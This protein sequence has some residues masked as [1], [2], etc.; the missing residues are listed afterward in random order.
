MGLEQLTDQMTGLQ[1]AN[2][3]KNNFE[4]VLDA[5]SAENKAENAGLSIKTDYD[6]TRYIDLQLADGT[7]V[8]MKMDVFCQAIAPVVAGL[9]GEANNYQRGLM[10]GMYTHV[11][12]VL[13]ANGSVN[14]GMFKGLIFWQ[15]LYS[16]SYWHLFFVDGKDSA[17]SL[18]NKSMGYGKLKT[19]GG[20][21]IYSTSAGTP[22]DF[23]YYILRMP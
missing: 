2:A 16:Y 5:E 15:D 1:M 6:A 11:K 18:S 21:V 4:K 12:T 10:P 8:K 13:P 9:I 14:L 3:I 17:I 23:D 19:E 22:T 7:P 20:S